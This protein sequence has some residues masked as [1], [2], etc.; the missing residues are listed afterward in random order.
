ME[1]EKPNT[2]SFYSNNQLKTMK[3]RKEAQVLKCP[4][5]K[6]YGGSVVPMDTK[7]KQ[8]KKEILGCL[9]MGGSVSV[10]PLEDFKMDYCDCLKE[11]PKEKKKN[12]TTLTLF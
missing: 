1:T 7:D 6:I 8:W 11:K 2:P 10:I 9:A 3:E 4:H 12:A 5:G